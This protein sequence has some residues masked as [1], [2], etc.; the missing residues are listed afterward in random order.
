MYYSP[1][2]A[3][4]IGQQSGCGGWDCTYLSDN[5]LGLKKKF[6]ADIL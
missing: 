1:L 3:H 5:V 6:S 4:H 2:H